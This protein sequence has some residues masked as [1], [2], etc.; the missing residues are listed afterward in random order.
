MDYINP[1]EVAN[2]MMVAAINK[3]K[4]SVKD[5]LIRGSLSGALLAI[6]V[7]LA[8]MAT[9]QT[10]LSLI[11]AFVF[12]VGFVIIVILGLELVTGSFSLVPLAW[13][14]KKISAVAMLTNL[15]W[16]FAGNLLG[17]VLFALM[18]WSATTE[19]GQ[20]SQIGAVEQ[21]LVKASEN[22]TIGYAQ[23]GAAGLFSAFVKAILCNWMV[24][25]GV[26]MSMTS[27]STLGKILAAGIPIFIFFALGYEHAVVNMF[28]IPAGMMFGA[29]VTLSDWWLYN[30]LIVTLGNIIGGLLFTGMGI[31]YTYGKEEKPVSSTI[32]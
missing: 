22:K 12:P 18:F 10:N 21:L 3:S 20:I 16:V 1:K 28:V 31:Y 23:H 17:S 19:T 5:L 13:F 6:S 29:N 2:T 7:T 15:F 26:V 11:G 32:K 25:M 14:E 4:L 24:C 8:F 27:R 30:Q 9:S